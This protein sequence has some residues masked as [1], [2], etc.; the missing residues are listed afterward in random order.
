MLDQARLLSQ[1]KGEEMEPSSTP[2]MPERG[3]G[4]EQQV[5]GGCIQESGPRLQCACDGLCVWVVGC[6]REVLMALL[7]GGALHP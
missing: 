4:G 1:A 7:D 3:G 6:C 2:T 5:V